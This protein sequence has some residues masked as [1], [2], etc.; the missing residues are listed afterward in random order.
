[1]RVIILLKIFF[2]L[3]IISSV[4]N[5]EVIKV[6][7]K[8]HYDIGY[9]V[10]LLEDK[11][12]NLDIDDIIQSDAFKKSTSESPNYGFSDS[13]VWCRITVSIPENNKKTWL[14]EIGYTLLDKVNFYS[15]KDG[16]YVAKRVGDTLPFS[17]RE[18]NH[19]NFVFYL[20]NTPGLYTYYI[21][22]ETT[23]S[24]TIPL[25]IWSL[26]S[27]ISQINT[28]KIIMGLIIGAILIMLL[29]N[30]FMVIRIKEIAYAY[31][32]LLGC[33]FG[34]FFFRYKRFCAKNQ[35]K[36]SGRQEKDRKRYCLHQQ[37]F[38]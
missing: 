30:F 36:T 14:L 37:T 38:I 22:V 20:D 10:D 18:I 15:K 33:C 27:F 24:F 6:G 2:L 11:S 35:R 32:V 8:E 1:M 29:Y 21:R 5:A 31:Y 26:T 28:E 3:F 13:V 25:K 9:Q 4:A 34:L 17:N 7:D 12:K 19:H 16:S 23:S